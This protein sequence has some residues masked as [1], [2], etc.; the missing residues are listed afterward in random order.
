MACMDALA[1]AHC[2]TALL[3]NV[4]ALLALR[5]NLAGGIGRLLHCAG[6]LLHRGSGF[7]QAAGLVFGAG[8]KVLRAGR[9]AC[10]GLREHAHLRTH[11][12]NHGAQIDLHLPH[13]AHQR[14]Q[15]MRVRLDHGGLEV[16][17]RQR[18]GK[19]IHLVD[20]AG[21][22]AVEPGQQGPCSYGRATPLR[23]HGGPPRHAQSHRRRPCSQY[24]RQTQCQPLGEG[25]P[26][27]RPEGVAPA[28]GAHP[29]RVQLE[30][31]VAAGALLRHLG[32]Q[33]LG[34]SH[35]F[36]GG[37]K[38]HRHVAHGLAVIEDGS[39][40]RLHPVVVAIGAAVFHGA[41]P[42]P[43]APNRGPHVLERLRR[44]VRVANQVVGLAHQL[45]VA[46]ATHLRKRCVAMGDVS[47]RIGGGHQQL[48]LGEKILFVRD[49]QVGTHGG[50]GQKMPCQ[51]CLLADAT[52]YQG[53]REHPRPHDGF[54]LRHQAFD[55]PQPT[56]TP[57]LR[58]ENIARRQ[59]LAINRALR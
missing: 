12:P 40:V 34:R 22:A 27:Q 23:R 2:G 3:G 37:P 1:L 54:D 38:A 51:P 46:V 7:L 52:T 55:L 4:A 21:H 28:Q 39:D 48:G 11:I 32:V 6:Q 15:H 5:G 58:Q 16:A 36:A 17:R 20:H 26:V 41:R 9:D 44:H 56:A 14:R 33:R 53:A 35:L 10:R 45:V 18:S 19:I 59:G 50:R 49:R 8:G 42:G 13:V 47:A 57:T 25:Q 29:A 31:V 43:T 24:T 30:G